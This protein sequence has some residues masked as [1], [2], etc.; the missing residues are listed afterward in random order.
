[1]LQLMSEPGEITALLAEVRD[2][3]PDAFGKLIAAVYQELRQIAGFHMRREPVNHTWQ[4]TVLVHEVCLRLL[5]S[6]SLDWRDREH[7]FASAGRMM[8]NL[9]VDHA[10][11]QSRIKRGGGENAISLTDA[12]DPAVADPEETLRLDEALT[13]LAQHDARAAQVVEL[14]CFL[15]LDMQ[16]CA[17]ALGVSERTVLRDWK[18]AKRWLETELRG[19]ARPRP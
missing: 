7:F 8:R 17:A 10:R 13:R 12:P 16:E 14:R 6:E 19:T 5:G 1:M 2:S 11:T 4:P 3:R 9:L 15:G 18:L